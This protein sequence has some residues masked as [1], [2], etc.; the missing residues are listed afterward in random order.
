MKTSP[1][2]KQRRLS[3][4]LGI[5]LVALSAITGWLQIRND[6]AEYSRAK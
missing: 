3:V 6:K 1:L 2:W 5:S 4:L